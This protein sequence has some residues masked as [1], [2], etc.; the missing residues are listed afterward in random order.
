MWYT[1][2]VPEPEL[3]PFT[4]PN[5]SYPI[6]PGM[7]ICPECG[8][9]ISAEDRECADRRAVFLEL[10]RTQAVVYPLILIAC[11]VWLGYG[12]PLVVLVPLLLAKFAVGKGEPTLHRKLLQRGW[13]I[14]LGWINAWW[15][16]GCAGY[17][18]VR[19]FYYE[20]YYLYGEWSEVPGVLSLRTGRDAGFGGVVIPVFLLL[21]GI[22]SYMLWRRRWRRICRVGGV[23]TMGK[24]RDFAPPWKVGLL[25]FAFLYPMLIVIVL[26][27]LVIGAPQMLDRF[28]PGW[29]MGP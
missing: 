19:A 15:I 6:N 16:L 24:E 29:D 22:A 1:A 17:R 14:T 5:C 28:N 4:C 11:A 9:H 12:I 20:S 25:R 7:Q 27:L 23:G 26:M 8:H 21:T 2:P 13:I 18:V 3:K 10:T